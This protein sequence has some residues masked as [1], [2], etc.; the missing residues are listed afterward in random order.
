MSFR[1]C[2]LIRM[3][4]VNFHL[5]LFSSKTRSVRA[6]KTFRTRVL[7]RTLNINSHLDLFSSTARSAI[8]FRNTVR[9]LCEFFFRRKILLKGG[10]ITFRTC[11]LIHT[12]NVKP[13]L[14]LFS[15]LAKSAIIFRNTVRGLCEFFFSVKRF[16]QGSKKHFRTSNANAHIARFPQSHQGAMRILHFRQKTLSR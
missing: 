9:G 2:F 12:S 5:D 8:V 13:H 3:S 4:N 16:C 15:S 1:T 7:I 11:F 10:N 6:G 14:D